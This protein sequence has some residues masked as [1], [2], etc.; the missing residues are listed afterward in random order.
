MAGYKIRVSEKEGVFDAIGQ[1]ILKDIRDLAVKG[2]T[3]ARFALRYYLDGDI[4]EAQ[5]RRIAEE[6]LIDKITQ[7]YSLDEGGFR[8]DANGCKTI[9]IAYN[10]G[11]MDPVEEA[12]LKAIADM[13]ISGVSS[14]RTAKQYLLKGKISE[15]ALK[16]ISE[17]LL[18][19]KVI[20]H[21]VIQ[22]TSNQKPEDRKTDYQ[23]K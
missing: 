4:N 7:E 3:G 11:V 22:E 14:V 19:N 5:A 10:P 8:H 18:Y 12:V 13:G 6:L 17:K 16:T 20:Q 9:E 23:F 15:G 21:I 1:G 2:V